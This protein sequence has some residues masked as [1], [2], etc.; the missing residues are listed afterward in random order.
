[1]LAE[2][3]WADTISDTYHFLLFTALW[4]ADP[5]VSVF[6]WVCAYGWVADLCVYVCVCVI[7]VDRCWQLRRITFLLVKHHID[8]VA[9]SQAEVRYTEAKQAEWSWHP[10]ES[11]AWTHHITLTHRAPWTHT[12]AHLPSKN[13]TLTRARQYMEPIQQAFIWHNLWQPYWRYAFQVR[14]Q[15]IWRVVLKLS[16]VN[17]NENTFKAAFIDFQA[18]NSTVTHYIKKLRD[19]L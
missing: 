7:E 19:S 1:M 12:D 3:N 17:K 13:P 14:Q 11:C 8:P 4:V 15:C 9:P 6:L 5:S 16:C 10:A 2:S 18:V